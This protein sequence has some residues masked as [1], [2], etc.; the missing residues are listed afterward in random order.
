MALIPNLVRNPRE[1]A[2]NRFA[3]FLVVALVLGSVWLIVVGS[4][5]AGA[6]PGAVEWGPRGV[7]TSPFAVRFPHA[8]HQGFACWQCHPNPFNR[9]VAGH[10]AFA[11]GR[12]CAI[13][14]DGRVA[15]DARPADAPCA[16]CHTRLGGSR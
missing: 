5:R 13:C 2:P 9:D 7:A 16:R 4:A 14:H 1:H 10:A 11:V 6:V 12:S 15:F 3:R 8:L